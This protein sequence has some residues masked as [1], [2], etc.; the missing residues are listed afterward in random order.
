MQLRWRVGNSRETPCC[1]GSQLTALTQTGILAQSGASL[2]SYCIEVP[3]A[4]TKRP[5]VPTWLGRWIALLALLAVLLLW[6]VATGKS[7]NSLLQSL[8]SPTDTMRVAEAANSRRRLCQNLLDRC[9]PCFWTPLT[10]LRDVLKLP[11]RL[12]RERTNSGGRAHEQ[13]RSSGSG[14]T[15]EQ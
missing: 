3:A 12:W 5:K 13:V 6:A 10:A 15:I 14:V 11:Q 4:H 8:R 1:T 9:L 7:L 2:I